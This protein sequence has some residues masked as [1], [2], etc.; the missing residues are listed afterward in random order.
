[1]SEIKKY[2]AVSQ[3]DSGH[4]TLTYLGQELRTNADG[5][6]EI[7][8]STKVKHVELETFQVKSTISSEQ[9][10]DLGVMG[11]DVAG[12][13]RSTL[14]NEAT[15]GQDKQIYKKMKLLGYVSNR[16]LWTKIQAIANKWVGYV[17][18][19][20]IS[21]EGSLLKRINLLRNQ[22]AVSA[23]TGRANFVIISPGLLQYFTEDNEF[24][25]SE[26]DSSTQV[27]LVYKCG[28]YRDEMDVLVNPS[29][30]W[31]DKRVVIGRSTTSM[32]E[33]V[34]LV[35]HSE[36]NIITK[37]SSI[38]TLE[39]MPMV[40]TILRSRYALVHTENAAKNYITITCTEK[41]HNIFT[42]IMDKY[43]KKKK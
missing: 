36:G 35:E 20:N 30:R 43:F 13:L 33:G 3:V 11:I 34:F 26:H 17:P 38:D 24:K 25:V 42:H 39:L 40:E 37:S 8:V 27:G 14:E 9:E 41:R 7:A 18:M 16:K 23:R 32:N 6:N 28:T 4:A 21:K 1:M 10:K 15:Q 5:T 22:I 19:V 29:I 2:I 31:T 12:M